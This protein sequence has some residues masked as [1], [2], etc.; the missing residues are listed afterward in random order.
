MKRPHGVGD[1]TTVGAASTTK[2]VLQSEPESRY[3]WARLMAALL[4]STLGGVGMWS[5]VVALPRRAGGVRRGAR[6]RVA[7][8]HAHHDLLRPGRHASWADCPTASA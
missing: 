5:V 6:R 1:P 7:A 3:A 8:L 2:G 4:L